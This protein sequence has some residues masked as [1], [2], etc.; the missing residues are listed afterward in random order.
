MQQNKTLN[1]VR[2]KEKL[3]HVVDKIQ[4]VAEARQFEQEQCYQIWCNY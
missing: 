2:L 4:E 3:S 1:R